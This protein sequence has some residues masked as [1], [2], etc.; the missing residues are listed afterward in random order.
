MAETAL[1]EDMLKIQYLVWKLEDAYCSTFYLFRGLLLGIAF[2]VVYLHCK[3]RLEI[4]PFA[5]LL[6]FSLF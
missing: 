1:R 3:K 6:P 2:H 4:F 5:P